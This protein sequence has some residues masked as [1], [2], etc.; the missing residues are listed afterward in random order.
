MSGKLSSPK[1]TRARYE[2]AFGLMNDITH[3]WT[4]CFMLLFA[5]VA[6]ALAWMH[7]AIGRM[8]R[9]R[10]PELGKLPQLPEMAELHAASPPQPQAAPALRPRQAAE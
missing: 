2:L 9:A 3:V 10:T 5:L 4:S 8:E 6:T 7:L 1:K